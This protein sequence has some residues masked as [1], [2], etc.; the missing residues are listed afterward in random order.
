MVGE[1]MMETTI[2]MTSAIPEEAG[3]RRPTA[4]AVARVSHSLESLDHSTPVSSGAALADQRMK[5]QRIKKVYAGVVR[6]LGVHVVDVEVEKNHDP[7]DFLVWKKQARAL[8][9]CAAFGMTDGATRLWL[10][11][12]GRLLG[13]KGE[14][15]ALRTLAYWS[16]RNRLPCAGTSLVAAA[17]NFV[18][19]KLAEE[20]KAIRGGRRAVPTFNAP[21]PLRWK[22]SDCRLIPSKDPDD[23]V[24][25]ISVPWRAN[26]TVCPWAANWEAVELAA[27]AKAAKSAGNDAS[28]DASSAAQGSRECRKVHP[29]PCTLSNGFV[30]KCGRIRLKLVAS[31]WRGID[32]LRRI[33]SGEYEFQ[34]FQAMLK[35]GK[36]MGSLS[37]VRPRVPRIMGGRSAAVVFSLHHAICIMTEDVKWH[38]IPAAGLLAGRRA[39]GER[40][41]RVQRGLS[42]APAGARGRGAKRRGRP[43]QQIGD[44]ERRWIDTQCRQIVAAALRWCREN[45]VTSLFVAEWNEASMSQ[46]VGKLPREAR[47]TLLQWPRGVL[48]RYLVEGAGSGSGMAPRTP[49]EGRTALEAVVVPEPDVRCLLCDTPIP[50]TPDRISSCSSC[51][52]SRMRDVVRACRVLQ[53]N[54]IELRDKLKA[55]QAAFDVSQAE[56]RRLDGDEDEGPDTGTLTLAGPTRRPKA[57]KPSV[58]K[59]Q[60]ELQ[61]LAKQAP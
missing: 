9:R 30:G 1:K 57:K 13:E 2:G 36:W 55:E 5:V 34:D 61:D 37:H 39:F 17:S 14:E 45:G 25:W 4:R 3:V 15:Q 33:R 56:L 43:V 59:E 49:A 44:K 42:T 46:L 7:L 24:L 47:K 41:A 58:R 12:H 23:P 6:R 52:A 11:T 51:G 35:N 54:G 8:G 38:A 18:Y 48:R 53:A 40:R 20:Q 29:H 26:A 19:S 28:D 27:R 22:G 60:H 21:T 10:R 31:G 50:W 16:V 32:T